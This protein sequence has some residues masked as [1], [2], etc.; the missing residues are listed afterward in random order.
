MSETDLTLLGPSAG[1]INDLS[2]Q[3]DLALV[4]H[5]KSKIA[6]HD[7]QKIAAQLGAISP[8]GKP[9][10]IHF[11]YLGQDTV[12]SKSGILINNQEP[13]DPRDQILLYNYAHAAGGQNPGDGWVGLESLP[14]SISKVRTLAVYG[15]QPIAELF[16]THQRETV[17]ARCRAEL[18]AE[19]IAGSSAAIALFFPVL[20]ML[21]LQVL[22][23]SAEPE[24]G[25]EA[26][27]KILFTAD[28]LD[29]LDIE[30]LVFT[31]ERLADRLHDILPP[32]RDCSLSS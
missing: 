9:D 19:E 10:T 6:G 31:A 4:Q 1:K 23:W 5:L 13:E 32:G 12:L 29:H 3:K 20:P 16:S 2:R 21:P 22:F 7:F 24:D 18:A 8:E 15:E 11:R 27:V 26:K 25:F 30:S 17:I 28:V 14:N